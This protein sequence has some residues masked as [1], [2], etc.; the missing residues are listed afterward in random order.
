MRRR[1]AFSSFSRLTWA[2]SVP[3]NRMLPP[4]GSIIRLMHRSTVDFP[5]PLGPMMTTTSPG[6]TEK[7]TSSTARVWP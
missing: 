5:A 6:L 4:V 1:M 2:M 3:W 7:V